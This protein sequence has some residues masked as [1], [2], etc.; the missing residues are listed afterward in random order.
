MNL[1]TSNISA[2]FQVLLST[3]IIIKNT[4]IEGRE[5]VVVNFCIFWG[6]CGQT[7]RASTLLNTGQKC[8]KKMGYTVLFL[9][10]TTKHSATEAGNLSSWIKRYHDSYR[11]P[12]RM[13]LW[14]R[15]LQLKSPHCRMGPFWCLCPIHFHN[16]IFKHNWNFKY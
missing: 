8:S 1:N 11:N 4:V 10:K 12:L 6:H 16:W 7:S 14:P 15:F 5:L 2:E 13:Q 9:I 3:L